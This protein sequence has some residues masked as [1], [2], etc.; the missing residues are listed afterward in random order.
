MRLFKEFLLLEVKAARARRIALSKN[1]YSQQ[2]QTALA[3]ARGRLMARAMAA[4]I[5]NEGIRAQDIAHNVDKIEQAKNVG[6]MKDPKVHTTYRDTFPVAGNIQKWNDLNDLAS[7]VKH[8]GL[9]VVRSNPVLKD[10]ARDAVALNDTLR[11]SPPSGLNNRYMGR[12]LRNLHG[13]IMRSRVA[14]A[15][16][17]M[18]RSASEVPAFKPE[19]PPT[20]PNKLYNQPKKNY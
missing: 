7:R 2:A 12:S 9:E 10:R 16:E 5:D 18:G 17:A 15:A 1:R 14:G 8:Q 11:N 13:H 19:P 3:S 20:P 6:I 4:D